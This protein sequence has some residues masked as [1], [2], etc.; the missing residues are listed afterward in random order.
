MDGMWLLLILCFLLV[1]N[2]GAY[3]IAYCLF[4]Y[5]LDRRAT[6]QESMDSITKDPEEAKLAVTMFQGTEA[7]HREAQAVSE[8]WYLQSH[9]GLR[10]FGLFLK[11]NSHRYAILCH[12]LTGSHGEMYGRA[13]FF[14]HKGFQVLMPDARAHGKSEGRYRGMGYVEKEDIRRWIDR[15]L[16]ADPEA[17]ILLM[18]ESMGSATVMMT[19]AQKLPPQV[20]G[21]IGDCGYTSVWDIFAYQL[22]LRYHLPAFPFMHIADRISKRKAG[23]SFREAS[24]LKHISDCHL[25]LLLIHG[26]GDTVV[27]W[28][29]AELIYEHA[30]EPKQKLIVEGGGHC[31]SM[32]K[33]PELYYDTIDQFVQKYFI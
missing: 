5:I 33:K 19:A 31:I 25:P 20:K 4:Y 1:G 30:N 21:V 3:A 2:G 12:G 32:V 23:Y 11:Q 14:Y 9:D 13:E 8:D 26:T 17:E 27:P 7:W 29:H 28:E 22:K 15:I 6:Y 10:L 24:P 18:G 16:S